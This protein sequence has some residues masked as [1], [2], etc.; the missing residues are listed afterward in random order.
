MAS[1]QHLPNKGKLFVHAPL[2]HMGSERKAP[3]T[4]NLSARQA[5]DHFHATD[6]LTPRKQVFISSE[7]EAVWTPETV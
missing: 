1:E 7:Q 3:C 6:V 4:L 5:S 2:K